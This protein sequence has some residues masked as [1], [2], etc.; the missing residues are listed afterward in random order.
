M[1]CRRSKRVLEELAFACRRREA[2]QLKRDA[3][4]GSTSRIR[5]PGL[6]WWRAGRIPG[7][8]F[9]ERYSR[10]DV[11]RFYVT[12]CELLAPSPAH[13]KATGGGEANVAIS[14]NPIG[15]LNINI[16]A[17]PGKCFTRFCVRCWLRDSQS[18]NAEQRVIADTSCTRPREKSA[19]AKRRKA[20]LPAT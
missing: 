3:G 10:W 20:A 13:W 15:V 7:H 19:M 2:D 17:E 1:R 16:G 4:A 14:N 12:L 5:G 18:N 11:K 9:Y 8:G 6:S